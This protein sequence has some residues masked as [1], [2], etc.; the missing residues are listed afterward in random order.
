MRRLQSV[1]KAYVV[2]I[3]C[4][5]AAFW[6]VIELTEPPGPSLD[7]DALAYLGAGT[8]LAHG[9]GLRVPSSGWASIDTTAPLVH[10]PPGFS[11]AIALGTLTGATPV[12]AARFVEGAAA[13][14]TAAALVLAADA[15]AGVV[16]SIAAIGIAAF[17]PA[18]VIVHAG[19]LSEPLF[20]AILALFTWR[21]SSERRGNDLKRT[22][23]LGALAA[24]ATLVRYAG[25]SLLMAVVLE[26]WWSVDGPWRATLVQRARRAFVAAEL[27]VA[28]LAL[29]VI[30]RP[31][32]EDAEKIREVGVYTQG[33]GATLLAGAQT[34]ERWFAPGTGA[35]PATTIAAVAVLGAIV[36]LVIR[37]LRAMFSGN[38]P[39]GEL[40]SHRATAIVLVSYA[41]V[42]GASRLL[43]DPGIPLD[44]RILA[45]VFLLLSLRIGVALAGFWRS[46]FHARR[47]LVM[48]TIGVVASWMWGSEEVSARW[49]N[50]YRTDG[51]DLAGRAWTASALVSW[52]RGAPAGTPLYSNWPAAIW[53]HTGRATHELPSDLDEGT[54]KEFRA[55][56]EREH[57][58]LLA[59]RVGAE[60]YAAPDS[61][62]VRAGLV[63]VER[64]P[65]GNIWR[66]PAD[67][68]RLHP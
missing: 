59:F 6:G 38:M 22:L 49:V 15:A 51:G 40:R 54:V 9:H 24:A 34:F 26:A 41:C 44:E 11:T 53:F 29:W 64:W 45:P 43:A 63:A 8:S 36:A 5:I 23:V 57:G 68:I 14:V 1:P 47:A 7:P 32:S 13:A 3:V 25:A 4:A 2:A 30:T 31:H 67:T 50:D 18:F 66:A 55:K 65:D 28:V 10:F 19:V 35:E 20:L 58:A 46:A 48:F 62:A 52:A 37:T 12:T 16:A 61:L 39:A 21:L 27:P 56:I 60:D 42:V 17:T 33:L